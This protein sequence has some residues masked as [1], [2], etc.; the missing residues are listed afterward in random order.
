MTSP[1]SYISRASLF[2]PALVCLAIGAGAWFFPEE[3]IQNPPPVAIQAH[4]P[5]WGDPWWKT[6]PERYPCPPYPGQKAGPMNPMGPLNPNKLSGGTE[7][8]PCI[9]ANIG[10]P[11]VPEDPCATG[12]GIPSTIAFKQDESYSATPADT[13]VPLYS[14]YMGNGD[15]VSGSPA[16]M[17]GEMIPGQPATGQG[18][19]SPYVSASNGMMSISRVDMSLPGGVRGFQL[20]R[21]YRSSLYNYNSFVGAGWEL[22][23]IQRIH[24]TTLGSANKPV[25]FVVMEGNGLESGIFAEV[26]SNTDW[27]SNASRLDQF[28]YVSGSPDTIIQYKEDG[29]KDTFT[30]LDPLEDIYY[31]SSSEDLYGNM[32]TFKYGAPAI[33]APTLRSLDIVTDDLGRDYKFSYDSAHGRVSRVEATY[34]NVVVGEVDYEY[35]NDGGIILLDS[36]KKGM[37]PTEHPTNGLEM[38]REIESYEYDSMNSSQDL[39]GGHRLSGLVNG[40]GEE[41]VSWEYFG[42]THA[43][44]GRVMKQVDRPLGVL[45]A[46]GTHTYSYSATKNTYSDPDGNYREFVLDSS[47]R[48]VERIEHIG[49]S[50]TVSVLFSYTSAGCAGCSQ[51]EQIT[52]EDGSYELF[53]YDD[54]GNMTAQ[55]W[56]PKTGSTLPP[57]V[58]RWVWSSFD[59]LG[60]KMR[61]RLRAHELRRDAN[62]AEDPNHSCN[63][64]TCTHIQNAD[65]HITHTFFWSADE[66]S[67]DLID[68][69]TIQNDSK[70]AGTTITRS[71]GFTYFPDGRLKESREYQDAVEVAR[72]E[73]SLD[74]DLAYVDEVKVVDSV[75]TTDWTTTYTR[76]PN[77]F[78]PD[79]ETGPDGTVTKV[80]V[81]TSGRPYLIEE[82]YSVSSGSERATTLRYDLAG[83]LVRIYTSSGSQSELTELNLDESGAAYEI[84]TTVNGGTKRTAKFEYSLGGLL[85]ASED[86]RGWRLETDYGMGSW[87]LPL[88]HR[89]IDNSA[90]SNSRNIWRAG[91]GTDDGYDDMGRLTSW[92][93]VMDWKSYQAYDDRG[94]PQYTFRQ[95]KDT[96]YSARA[97]FYDVRGFVEE[98]EVGTLNGNP[99]SFTLANLTWLQHHVFTRNLAGH[100]LAH[101]VFESGNTNEARLTQF[102]RDGRGR[103][104]RKTGYQGDRSG[105]GSPTPVVSETEYDALNRTLQVRYLASA[106]TNTPIGTLD[107]WYDDTLRTSTFVE[108]MLDNG[109][110]KKKI[111]L[112]RDA[113]GRLITKT[114][115]PWDGAAWGTGREWDYTYDGLDSLLSM[116]DPM[117]IRT[118]W[119]GN[120]LG[121]ILTKTVKPNVGT[122]S[123]VT[124]YQYDSVNSLLEQV[125][126][127]EGSTTAYTYHDAWLRPKTVTYPDNRTFTIDT[128]DDL[129]RRDQTTDSRGVIHDYGYQ[130]VYLTSD[131]V[132]KPT[133]PVVPGPDGMSWEYNYDQGTID[134]AWVWEN[135]VQTWVT[136]YTFN[137]LGEKTAETQGMSGDAQTWGW[138]YG[139]AGELLE[140]TY[141]SGLGID[142]GALS[143]DTSGRVANIKYYKGSTLLSDDAFTYQ[144]FRAQKRLDSIAGIEATFDF[145]DFGRLD[146]MKWSKVTGGS[147]T[148]LDGQQRVF[149]LGDRVTSRE[150]SLDSTG[151]VFV[152]DGYGRMTDW[153]QGVTNAN[154]NPT[155]LANGDWTDAEH[156]TLTSVYGR[157]EVVKE[158]KNG[159]TTP[160]DYTDNPAHFYDSVGGVSRTEEHGRL[161]TDGTNIFA[162][163]AWGRLA[164]VSQGGAIIRIHTYDAEG[165]RVKTNDGSSTRRL[166]YWGARLAATFVEGSPSNTDIRTY[167]YAGGADGESF[168]E[169][170]GAGAANGSYALAR[171]SQGSILAMIDRS[172]GAVVERYRYTPFGGVSIEDASGTGLAASAYGNDRFF[173]GRVF[174]ATV[175][176]YD[177]RAR[178]YDPETGS[179]LAPDPLGA[180]DSWNMYQYGFGAP[181]SWMDP[182]GLQSE[183]VGL[184]QG[185]IDL[186][187]RET[188]S[189]APDSA[190][191]MD[192][193][194]QADC[195]RCHPEQFGD[196]SDALAGEWDDFKN[197]VGNG[198]TTAA[199][200]LILDDLR[201]MCSSDAS[202]LQKGYVLGSY[203]LGGKIA[204]LA[205]GAVG[206][207]GGAIAKK[208]AGNGDEVA[209]AGKKFY[210]YTDEA[211]AVKIENSQLGIPDTTLFLTPNGGLSPLQA[212]IELALPSDNTATAL[213]EV[214]GDM[215]DS[216]KIIGG[217][218]VTGNVNGRA[219]GGIELLIDGAIGQFNRI[220]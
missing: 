187:Q 48:I 174:D 110:D 58:E 115:Y 89:Q 160:I 84:G 100:L 59:P 159:P 130:G 16:S 189:G 142:N 171:D 27:F 67:L 126:D 135:G 141:P 101:T 140:V 91:D 31:L 60:G 45:R 26:S 211:T 198:A 196:S 54:W 42:S 25:E 78:F 98:M 57:R 202:L 206:T 214:A 191:P 157:D 23:S 41:Y 125:T 51:V 1:A 144:G 8:G 55:W 73:Y 175:G 127:A 40:K 5:T 66:K 147:S 218:R 64:P 136:D 203:I 149:D 161:K 113:L 177:L 217:G 75:N 204:R 43:N 200:A 12:G 34:N 146:E 186:I 15:P 170:S 169:I 65:G 14:P 145:D 213:F 148:V 79:T 97:Y 46:P 183:G 173:M 112:E 18:L 29:S 9:S 201:T 164:T 167:G 151:D 76:T 7:G 192:G 116:E 158:K 209:Q 132:T 185:V 207:A 212:Q 83:Q 166:V 6:D 107:A 50:N 32:V 21:T 24:V 87:R 47:G 86:W 2:I 11:Y 121:Q 119:V 139:Y 165:R 35:V 219:G 120:D 154:A 124:S 80:T 181:A 19:D 85:E 102:V 176:I 52:Y 208:L 109:V 215:L 36:V 133:L 216:T 28:E 138:E 190:D 106:T 4:S 33:N 96:Y 22:N 129:G 71:A 56:Y 153:Y 134:K 38:K 150:R 143:Y 117:D 111:E 62:P 90:A 205:G 17:P 61:T 92:R 3:K 163:D 88:V 123:L 70:G 10:A 95:Q 63:H 74:V 152:H 20:G 69:G 162:W 182:F 118:E 197:M 128:Y 114:Q 172:T 82:N 68:Y 104:V 156:Y 49:S 37:I 105:S 184:P 103:V 30:H 168:V 179:F 94:R 53:Q 99:T 81:S 93:N 13:G 39:Y 122:A 131:T 199:N 210:H 44:D 108:T 193:S 178:W 180:V 195:F 155:F 72:V 220:R 188:N 77:T 137:D 194:N